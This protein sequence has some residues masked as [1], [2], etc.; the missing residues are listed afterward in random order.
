MTVDKINEYAD[1][2]GFD[3]N[4]NFAQACYDQ[5]SIEELTT[6]V[7]GLKN[8]NTAVDKTD[9]ATWNITEQQWIDGIRAACEQMES[10]I[11]K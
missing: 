9:C 2:N 3:R 6:I 11:N 7:I 5:N 8:G 10:E 4:N 1:A